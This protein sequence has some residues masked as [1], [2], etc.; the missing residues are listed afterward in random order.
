[1]IFFSKREKKK[2]ADPSLAEQYMYWY[3]EILILQEHTAK[4][5]CVT[6]K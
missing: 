5:K 3:V 1:M 4:R 6:L 2:S